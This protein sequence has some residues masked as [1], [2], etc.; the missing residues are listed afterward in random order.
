[1]IQPDCVSASRGQIISEVSS[2]L[3]TNDPR[4]VV[5]VSGLESSEF[6]HVSFVQRWDTQ[7]LI[8]PRDP[9]Q[10]PGRLAG[11]HI[12]AEIKSRSGIGI[13][14]LSSGPLC[15]I[16]L[17]K[18]LCIT[19]FVS[20]VVFVLSRPSHECKKQSAERGSGIPNRVR[21]RRK[22]IRL[23]APCQPWPDRGR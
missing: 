3:W 17:S 23:L 12:P 6:R 16:T 2:P 7:H 4:P 21:R 20:V 5:V 13:F 18:Y 19:H 15:A 9:N 14:T 8:Q 10:R 11:S 22:P 1:M